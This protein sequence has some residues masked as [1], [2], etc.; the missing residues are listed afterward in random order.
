VVEEHERETWQI[1]EKELMEMVGAGL[2]VVFA[3]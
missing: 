3:K 2:S 1:I